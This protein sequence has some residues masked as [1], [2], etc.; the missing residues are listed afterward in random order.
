[1]SR[2]LLATDIATFRLFGLAAFC[3]ARS[4]PACSELSRM[5]RGTKAEQLHLRS[6]AGVGRFVIE[7]TIGNASTVAVIARKPGGVKPK[8]VFYTGFILS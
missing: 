1:M 3:V 6:L 7:F 8:R 4:G 5:P 2:K